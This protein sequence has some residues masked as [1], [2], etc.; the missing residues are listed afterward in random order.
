VVFGSPSSSPKAR[1]RLPSILALIR[2]FPR[3]ATQSHSPSERPSWSVAGARFLMEFVVPLLT[4]ARGE[5]VTGLASRKSLQDNDNREECL[6]TEDPSALGYE[7]PPRIDNDDVI[8]KMAERIK[9]PGHFSHVLLPPFFADFSCAAPTR[10]KTPL[11]PV[12]G[13]DVRSL[14]FSDISSIWTRPIK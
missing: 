14:L 6:Q 13:D 11:V 7:I 5:N 12:C 2:A 1:S 9:R 10:W 4:P 8:G 3:T